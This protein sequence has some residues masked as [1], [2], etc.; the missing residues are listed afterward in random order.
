MGLVLPPYTRAT[1]STVVPAFNEACTIL[2]RSAI[3][4]L[5]RCALAAFAL[6]LLCADPS[7]PEASPISPMLCQ[8]VLAVRLRMACHYQVIGVMPARF[9]VNFS[10]PAST[11]AW[12]APAWD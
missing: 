4:H 8:T 6:L 3:V 12:I 2:C 5:W 10:L 9:N 11:Q 7:T 1:L